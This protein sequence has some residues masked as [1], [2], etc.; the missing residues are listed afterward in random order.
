MLLLS[1]DFPDQYKAIHCK[2]T[3][4]NSVCNNHNHHNSLENLNVDKFP[5][6]IYSVYKSEVYC[7]Y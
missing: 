7:K 5:T 4:K 1:I 2:S 6:F 3:N